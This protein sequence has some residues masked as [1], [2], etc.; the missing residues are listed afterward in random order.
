MTLILKLNGSFAAIPVKPSHMLSLPESLCQQWYWSTAMAHFEQ[1]SNTQSH[2]A[3]LSQVVPA[4]PP[5][6]QSQSSLATL[7]AAA[8][9]MKLL[10]P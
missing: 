1:V 6:H 7:T 10:M 8:I 3:C 4:A 5:L 2:A 9:K